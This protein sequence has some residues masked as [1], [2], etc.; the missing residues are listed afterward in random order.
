MSKEAVIEVRKED[1]AINLET[2]TT[3]CGPDVGLGTGTWISR[4][5]HNIHLEFFILHQRTLPE[6]CKKIYKK[7]VKSMYFDVKTDCSLLTAVHGCIT[8]SGAAGSCTYSP[9]S[10][11]LC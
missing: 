10:R 11:L 3:M 1:N 5:M 7:Y 6:I 4:G 2:F 9:P 8:P